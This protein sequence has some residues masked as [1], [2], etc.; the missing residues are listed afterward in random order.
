VKISAHKPLRVDRRTT[1]KWLA[2]SMAA[3][4]AG[5][6]REEKHLGA[7]IP[8]AGT[9]E[10]LG[11][12]ATPGDAGYGVDPDLMSPVVPWPRTMTEAQLAV[13]A[14]L[15]DM[16]LPEDERSPAASAV[17]VPD[18]I[19]EWISAP[20]TQQ[21][22]DRDVVLGG[23]EWLEHQSR[24]RFD[25]SFTAAAEAQRAD[26]VDS[27]AFPVASATDLAGQIEFFRLFRFLAVG[28]FY[29]TEQGMQDV[30]YVGNVAISGD[31]PGP[32]DEAMQHLAGVLEQLGLARPD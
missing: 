28:A 22:A 12:A 2:A 23:L 7:E 25:A 14:T 30:G 26:L 19:D 6:G 1:I 27:L 8:P 21:R 13:A 24:S 18:F 3:A 31:Y 15:C 4:Q 10:L 29:S 9:G 5:C 16:I 20:Y 32:S 11:I 17:G